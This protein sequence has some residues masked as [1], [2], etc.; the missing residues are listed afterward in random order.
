[1]AKKMAKKTIARKTRKALRSGEVARQAG[2]NGETLRYYERHGFL[3]KPPRTK[4]GYR[5]YSPDTVRRIRFIK[6][7]QALGFSLREIKE[8]LE[9]SVG[10]NRKLCTDVR[11]RAEA[12]L[13][14]TVEKIRDLQAIKRSLTKLVTSCHEKKATSECPILEALDEEESEHE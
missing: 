3:E 14:A 8:L 4:S 10:Q 11:K 9:L 13:T 6:R 7:A 1:M 2:V 5:L 12:K